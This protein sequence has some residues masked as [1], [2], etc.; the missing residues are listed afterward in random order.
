[1]P[2]PRRLLIP[3]EELILDLRPHPVALL[4]PAVV[5]IVR[6][7]G[8]VWLTANSTRRWIRGGLLLAIWILV[9]V[10]PMPQADPRG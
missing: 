8:R 3:D 6:A 10:Y 9:L 1:M 2:F 5:T 7:R 4:V